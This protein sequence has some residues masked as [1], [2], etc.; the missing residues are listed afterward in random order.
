MDEIA[1]ANL[2]IGGSEIIEGSK[3]VISRNLKGNGRERLPV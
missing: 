2:W 3:K 1:E